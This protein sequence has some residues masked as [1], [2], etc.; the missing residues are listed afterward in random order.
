[1]PDGWEEVAVGSMRGSI[2]RERRGS[3]GFGYDPVFVA[4][5][6]TATSAELAPQDKDRISHRGQ[7][8]RRMAPVVAAALADAGGALPGD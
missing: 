2:I 5:G 1:M 8:L 4:E 3:G 7:A 6:H